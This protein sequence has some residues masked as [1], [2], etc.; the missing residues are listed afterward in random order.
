MFAGGN[1]RGGGQFGGDRWD[2]REP[3]E[4][5]GRETSRHKIER[6]RF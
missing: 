5:G 4:T 6:D 2:E 1:G 3:G